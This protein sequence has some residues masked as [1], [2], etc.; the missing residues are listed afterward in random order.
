MCFGYFR[1][2]ACACVASQITSVVV[3]RFGVLHEGLQKLVCIGYI[4]GC[5]L[6]TKGG[7][8][9]SSACSGSSKN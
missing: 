6:K 2:R 1:C 3:Q 8:C 5:M 7:V 4:C 9:E